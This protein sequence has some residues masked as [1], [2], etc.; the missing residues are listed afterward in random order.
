MGEHNYFNKRIYSEDEDNDFLEDDENFDKRLLDEI[1]PYQCIY[2]PKA[3]G[4]EIIPDIW[5]SIAGKL[6]KNGMIFLYLL[7]TLKLLLKFL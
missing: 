6:G 5:K 7:N 4:K 1:R 3:E 2:N